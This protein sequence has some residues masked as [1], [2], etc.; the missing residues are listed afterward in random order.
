MESEESILVLMAKCFEEEQS[1]AITTSHSFVS[2]ML[3]S[4]PSIVRIWECF[5]SHCPNVIK[6]KNKE[7]YF[8]VEIFYKYLTISLCYTLPGRRLVMLDVDSGKERWTPS[9][10]LWTDSNM[11]GPKYGIHIPL[12]K[13]D[14]SGSF[15]SVSYWGE[16]KIKNDFMMSSVLV[17]S[18]YI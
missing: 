4:F 18:I 2:G 10:I 16:N 3:Y 8:T 5:I 13:L 6:K 12:M 17:S 14:S 9:L 11:N 15:N 7:G 1:I